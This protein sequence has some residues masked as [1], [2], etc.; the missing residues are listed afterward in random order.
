MFGT[1]YFSAHLGHICVCLKHPWQILRKFVFE[2]SLCIILQVFNL[3]LI[4]KQFWL[5]FPIHLCLLIALSNFET[6]RIYTYEK[7]KTISTEL[8]PIHV[9]RFGIDLRLWICDYLSTFTL[10]VTQNYKLLLSD[11][12]TEFQIFDNYNNLIYL[13]II[14][15]TNIKSNRKPGTAQVGAISKAER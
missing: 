7:K 4:Q 15:I 1:L 3:C 6:L 8:I 9:L 12:S 2:A 14:D 11:S 5:V 13:V 10:Q